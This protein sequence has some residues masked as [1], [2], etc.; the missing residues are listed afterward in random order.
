MTCQVIDDGP[1]CVDLRIYAGDSNARLVE[2]LLD[3]APW[4][5]VGATVTAQVRA[6]AADPVVALEATISPHMSDVGQFKMQWDGDS[7]RDLLGGEESW[8]GVWDLQVAD[9]QGGVWTVAR[10]RATVEMDVTR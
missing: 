8:S 1:L 10:G 4:P 6:T 9:A 3:G 7:A 2:L 5:L